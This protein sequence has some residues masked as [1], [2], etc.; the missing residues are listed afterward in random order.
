MK[1]GLYQAPDLSKKYQSTIT[2]KLL[3]HGKVDE[4]LTMLGSSLS[5]VEEDVPFHVSYAKNS[6][7]IEQG[8]MQ[9]ALE[10]AVALKEQMGNLARNVAGGAL[11]YT[12]NLL[13]IAC[14]QQELKNRPGEK[15]AWEELE[16]Y[17]EENKET[18][19]TVLRNFSENNVNLSQYIAERKKGL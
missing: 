14:L 13:R 17:L 3:I 1:E 18:A 10:S 12:H 2:Q 8:H 11:L 7:S 6:L 4:A 16:R 9:Q 5:R 19:D 15:A